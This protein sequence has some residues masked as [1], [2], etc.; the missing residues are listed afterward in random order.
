MTAVEDQ[1]CTGDP[2]T[3]GREKED[4]GIRNV[5][6]LPQPQWVALD[7]FIKAARGAKRRFEHGRLYKTWG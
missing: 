5:F 4:G 7:G 6:R 2:A 3:G 1:G